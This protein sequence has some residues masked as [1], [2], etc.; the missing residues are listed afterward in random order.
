MEYKLYTG[1]AMNKRFGSRFKYILLLLPCVLLFQNCSKPN[2]DS[3]AAGNISE[4]TPTPTPDCSY[5]WTQ[6]ANNPVISVG[7]S[8]ANLI[9]NDP[10]VVK[11][12]SSYYM[13]LSGG[14]AAANPVTNIYMAISTDGINWTFHPTPVLAPG[15]S[16]SWDDQ[17]IE[18]PSVVFAAGAFHMYYSA[19]AGAC[20][21][22]A[23]GHATSV[24]GITWTKDAANPLIQGHGD[25][26]Y[27]GYNGAGEPGFMYDY[28]YNVGYLYYPVLKNR[29]G[30]GGNQAVQ[31]AI[32]VATTTDFTNFTIFDTNADG[33]PEPIYEQSAHYPVS[34]YFVGPSTPMG[35]IDSNRLFHLFYDHAVFPAGD[36]W[37]QV[38]I[39]HATGANAFA[40]TEQ[41]VDILKVNASAPW[42]QWEVLAPTVV[43]EG[44]NLRMWF[45]G[46]N[47][48]WSTYGIGMA[49][50]AKPQGCQ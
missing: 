36:Q 49:T 32:T 40:V 42:L 12:G 41:E 46:R 26:T 16:G 10:T 13:W 11:N 25:M 6:Y 38:S 48:D 3:E 31:T 20:T 29:P 30:Y 45:A 33:Y 43:Q 8:I 24:D 47:F 14:I 35:F 19:C 34:Q 5:R 7:Q 23:I 2:S 15:A 28:T 1:E 4:A 37:H 21:V 17:R 50:Y 18:T 27:Y 22:Y 9:W 39:A 44:D